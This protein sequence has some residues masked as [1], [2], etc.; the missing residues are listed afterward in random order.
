MR[1]EHVYARCTRC[2]WR[3][4]SYTIKG[5]ICFEEYYC[6][7]CGGPLLICVE[8]LNELGRNKG[9]KNIM[10]QACLANH[11]CSN[12][13]Y[14]MHSL[15]NMNY[16]AE[17]VGPNVIIDRHHKHVA[18]LLIPKNPIPVRSKLGPFPLSYLVILRNGGLLAFLAQ[19]SITSHNR[20]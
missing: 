10:A 1:R 17:L 14:F 5:K 18:P 20:R 13:D 6:L 8:I 9:C 12:T 7:G 3:Q 15:K 11:L 2:G 16:H 19:W 4:R